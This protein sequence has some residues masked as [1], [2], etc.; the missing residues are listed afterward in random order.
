MNKQNALITGNSSGLGL[1]LSK[2]LL[3]HGYR[4]FGCSRR[5]CLLPGDIVDIR[6]DLSQLDR[7]SDN[8]NKL[9]SGIENLDLVILN[10]G[11][12]GEI[13]HISKTSIDELLHIMDI[14]LWSNKIILDWFLHKDININQILLVSSGAS[15]MGNKGWGGYA[16]SKCALNM[17]GRLY[18]HELP[19][20]HITAISPGLVESSMMDYLCTQA[21]KEKYPAIDRIQQARSDGTI[22][23]PTEAAERILKSL[24]HLKE[25]ESGS[26][27][28]LRQI[29]APDE[30]NAL[31]EARNKI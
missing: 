7:I 27:I 12:L 24:P 21:D 2:L 26:Y 29:L 22:L 3:S 10:A 19:E 25:Y 20:T 13:K 15:V 11:I 5:G 8:L 14:N 28:D 18:A 23:S 4:V 9:C 1:G 6:C 16:L 31:L 17:L 30:Y